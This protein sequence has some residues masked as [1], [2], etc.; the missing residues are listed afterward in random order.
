[1]EQKPDIPLF[2]DLDGTLIATDFLLEQIIYMIK[3][4]PFSIFLMLF[5]LTKGRPFLKSKLAEKTEISFKTLPLNHEFSEFIKAEKKRGRTLILATATNKKCAEKIAEQTNLFSKV[6]A[7]DETINLKSEAKLAKI[8]EIANGQFAYA[9]NSNADLPIWNESA[10]I[11]AVATSKKLRK[12][13]ADKRVTFF[14]T[15]KNSAKIWLK[16]IRATQWSKNALLFF[17][18]FLAHRILEMPLLTSALIAAISFSLL[19]SAIYI[20]NDLLDLEADRQHPRKKN[21]PLAAGKIT[22]QQAFIAIAA[23]LFFSAILL[24]FLPAK[25]AFIWLIY[26]LINIAYSIRIK[27]MFLLDV[28][29]LSQMYPL[30]IFAGSAATGVFSSPWLIAFASS[31]FFSLAVV[32]R[33]AELR[34]AIAENKE[35]LSGRN[36][37]QR[38]IGT[39]LK[40]GISF[41]ATTLLVFIGYLNSN[42]VKELYANPQALGLILPL[43]TYWIARIWALA[44]SGKLNDDPVEFALMDKQT[45]VIGA[46]AL[47]VILYAI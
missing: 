43:I 35:K 1:M 33:F 7:S 4:N 47:A 44:I 25:F 32:K 31:I 16:Q 36:Y 20:N 28:L 3:K 9:G 6:L 14:D 34:E 22:I 21:R 45:Y 39:L 24:F 23:L 29:V 15:R 10:E 27:H 30:R 42:P 37:H 8:K 11:I 2:V 5:W 17:P 40:I 46:L 19:A 41:A 13:L 38:N 26:L 12:K 18:I